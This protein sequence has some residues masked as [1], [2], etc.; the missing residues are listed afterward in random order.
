[1]HARGLPVFFP[2]ILAALALGLAA[3]GP[4]HADPANDSLACGHALS[5]PVLAK[6][7]AAGGEHGDL[8]CPVADEAPAADARR[9][10]T[11]READFTG[12]IIVWH[13]TGPR[14][15]QTFV[16]VGC[17]WRRYFQF[18]GTQGWLGLP[19]GDLTNTPDGRRQ[20]FEGGTIIYTRAYDSC[21]AEPDASASQSNASAQSNSPAT[22]S[23]A[24]ATSPLDLFFY[25]ARGDY[26]TAASAATAKT[27]TEDG[28]QRVASQAYVLTE[29]AKGA[30]PLKLFFNEAA[31]DHLT[32]GT[33]EGEHNAL[34]TGYEFEA[35]QGFVW[36]DPHPGALALKQYRNP[37][38]GHHLLVATPDGEAEAAKNGFVFERIEG[39]A[40]G[41]Q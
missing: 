30:V 21:D 16:V 28:Y 6:W 13:A 7:N 23:A 34:A 14:A 39:Y 24:V 5:A 10:S 37:S 33:A 26:I 19:L 35:S 27:A 18:G 40:P 11:A 2:M 41:T 31:G 17:A 4:A 38:S 9:G 25:P 36:A 8:G 29:Q 12:G 15:G 22:S 3:G 20:A 32:V 1:M